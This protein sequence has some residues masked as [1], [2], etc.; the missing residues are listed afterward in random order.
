[1]E[2]EGDHNAQQLDEVERTATAVL[3]DPHQ[4]VLSGNFTKF[5]TIASMECTSGF[6]IE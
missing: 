4:G 2:E 6:G 5:L 3:T 1:M